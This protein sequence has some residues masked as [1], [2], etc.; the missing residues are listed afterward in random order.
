MGHFGKDVYSQDLYTIFTSETYSDAQ[1]GAMHQTWLECGRP[2]YRQNLGCK[3]NDLS[4]EDHQE[5][6]LPHARDLGE[7]FGP[8]N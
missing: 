3:I 8:G 7:D 4:P 6:R 2:H 1:V 5:L